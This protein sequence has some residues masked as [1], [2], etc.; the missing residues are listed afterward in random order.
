MDWNNIWFRSSTGSDLSTNEKR[1]DT[2]DNTNDTNNS[3]ADIQQVQDDLVKLNQ[4]MEEIK[5]QLKTLIAVN[6]LI[7]MKIYYIV[8]FY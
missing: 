4:S 6:D 7:K 5:G 3:S 1:E 2:N 8:F